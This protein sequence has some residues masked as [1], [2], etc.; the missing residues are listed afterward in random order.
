MPSDKILIGEWRWKHRIRMVWEQ[1]KV[2][3][4][5]TA[6]KCIF[7]SQISCVTADITVRH[8]LFFLLFPFLCTVR[9]ARFMNRT[10]HGEQNAMIGH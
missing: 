10:Y 6:E 2:Y 8:C 4:L 7:L 3:D 1:K 5:M 9:T